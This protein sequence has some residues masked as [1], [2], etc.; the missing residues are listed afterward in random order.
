MV[1]GSVYATVNEKIGMDTFAL[2]YSDIRAS[3]SISNGTATATGIV[4]GKP[5]VATKVSIHLYLQQ[6]KNGNWNNICD[7]SESKDSTSISLLKSKTIAKGYKY[8][9]KAVCV[10]YAGSKSEKATVYSSVESY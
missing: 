1:S 8:R 2:Y 4:V 9:T 7:W 10:T 3:I 6:Y 5:G